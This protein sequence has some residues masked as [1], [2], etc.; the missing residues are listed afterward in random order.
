MAA[1]KMQKL[2]L[3]AKIETTYG[4]DATPTGAANAMLVKNVTITP[5]EGEEIQRDLV[6]PYFGSLGVILAGTYGKIDFEVELA[7]S[8]T[9]GTAPFWGVL[10]RAC[11]MS[12]TV[13]AATSVTYAPV[14]AGQESATIWW[15]LDGTRHVLLGARGTFSLSMDAQKIPTLKFT[16]TGLLGTVTDV[17][18]P[19]TTLPTP[20]Q[21]LPPSKTNTPTF[22]L[23]SYSAVVEAFSIDLGNKVEPR[24]L[25]GS[26]SIE[27]G[28]RAF[29]GSA[30]V[31]ADQV[32]GVDWMSKATARTRAALAVTHG[33]TAGNI[34]QIAAP[35]VEIGKPTH[36]SSN[37]ILNVTLP[38]V[39]CPSSASGNDE[40]SI[41]VK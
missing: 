17:A 36:G 11:A 16:L 39:F 32:A 23:H 3:L 30:T 38:L 9:A 14:S 40:L 29:T 10:A 35:A 13:V 34:I 20:P 25:I 18:L 15:N 24:L 26:E 4:T 19:A 2:A 22:S 37:N 31:Q 1:R 27:H 6:M 41:V 5:L 7:G 28:A 21:P 8:G 12:E 33:L